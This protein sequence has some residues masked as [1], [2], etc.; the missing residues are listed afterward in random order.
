LDWYVALSLNAIWGTIVHLLY[1][2][3]MH[4]SK[5]Q[6][7]GKMALGIKVVH[8]DGNKISYATAISRYLLLDLAIGLGIATIVSPQRAV[9]S[10][11]HDIGFAD[12]F[13][14][15]VFAILLSIHPQKRG[16]HDLI[17]DTRVVEVE[18]N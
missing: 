17:A 11:E 4:G 1:F 3:G 12:A 13:A 10:T 6:T 14:L 9:L 18:K 2:A 8:T 5:G 16:W 15:A 7:I